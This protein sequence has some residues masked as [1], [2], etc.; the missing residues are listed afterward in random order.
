MDYFVSIENSGYFYWQIDL[1]LESFKFAKINPPLVAIAENNDSLKPA[2]FAKNI[3]SHPKKFIHDNIGKK[4]NYPP[5]NKPYAITIALKN[6]ILSTPFAVTHPDMVLVQPLKEY[7]ENIVFHATPPDTQIEKAVEPY[8]KEFATANK[9]P[10]DKLP[11]HIPIGGAIIFNKVD[12]GFFERVIVRMIQL[13]KKHQ[14]EFNV[15]KAAWLITIYEHLDKYTVKGIS[16]EKNLIDHEVER[17]IIHYNH[18]LPPLFNKKF[19]GF[20]EFQIMSNPYEI[21]LAYNPTDATNYVQKIVNECQKE[22][23]PP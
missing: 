3:V 17:P 15:A 13:H 19:Y 12:V 9:I 11:P 8:L 1:L 4:Y 7:E 5:L 18:G 10:M 2:K 14:N 21:L 6:K 20:N 16:L 23:R 22:Q